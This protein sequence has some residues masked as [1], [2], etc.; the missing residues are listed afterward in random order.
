MNGDGEFAAD[1]TKAEFWQENSVEEMAD[2]IKNGRG[3]MPAFDLKSDQI[4]A[5]LDYVSTFRRG[6]K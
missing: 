1:F 2:V 4:Q 3:P 6:E 5:L